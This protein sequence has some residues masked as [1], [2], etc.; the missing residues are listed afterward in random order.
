MKQRASAPSKLSVPAFRRD[1]RVLE[2]EVVRQLE[3]ETTCCGVSLPQCHVL[4]EL[5]FKD[6]S[7]TTLADTLNLDKSTLSRT[8]EAMVQADLVERTTVATNRRSVRLTLT[9]RGRER[10]KSINQL[11]NRYYGALLRELSEPD[12]REAVRIVRLLAEA[13]KRLRDASS[14]P[15]CCGSTQDKAKQ[16]ACSATSRK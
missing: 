12:Q 16:T 14:A 4:L 11:C 3:G 8:I 13:M 6:V 15:P 5:S 10:V 2:R 7:L 1:L 9:K